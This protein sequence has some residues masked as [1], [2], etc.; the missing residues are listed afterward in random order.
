MSTRHRGP[1]R[2]EGKRVMIEIPQAQKKVREARF[3]L[4]LLRAPDIEPTRH[5]KETAIQPVEAR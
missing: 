3:F 5:G 2:A 4:D 1:A